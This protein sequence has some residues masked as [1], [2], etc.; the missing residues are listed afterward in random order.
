[1]SFFYNLKISAKVVI[2]FL[3]VALLAA[4]GCKS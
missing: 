3:I 2:G 1:M 4:A